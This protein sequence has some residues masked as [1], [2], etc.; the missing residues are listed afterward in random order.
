MCY[1]YFIN[2]IS[3]YYHI[4][5]YIAYLLVFFLTR[6]KTVPRTVPGTKQSF[7]K[8]LLNK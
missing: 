3:L 1:L 7:H 2:N 6:M 8:N 4:I 5:K